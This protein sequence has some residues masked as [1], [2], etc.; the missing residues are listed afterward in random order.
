MSRSFTVEA[1]VLKRSNYGEADRLVTLFTKQRGKLTALAKGVRKPTSR[2]RGSLEPASHGHF[3]LVESHGFLI[4]TEARLIASHQNLQ[5]NLTRL[6]QATQ[7]LEIVNAL[8]AENQEMPEI[9]SHITQ[10]L[11]HLHEPGTKKD[12]LVEKT[13]QLLH[14]LGFSPHASLD[15]YALKEL[16]ESLTGKKLKTKK[17]LTV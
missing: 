3:Q 4:L 10:A 17:F 6:T 1:I 7:M 5:Q 13:N 8:T 12:F 16:I 2:K 9:F 14:I 15:E 11:K